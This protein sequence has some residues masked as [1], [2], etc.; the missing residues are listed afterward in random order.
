MLCVSGLPDS[1]DWIVNIITH[2]GSCL[3]KRM[4]EADR[5]LDLYDAR[6]HVARVSKDVKQPVRRTRGSPLPQPP[7]SVPIPHCRDTARIVDWDAEGE[8][9]CSLQRW[10]YVTCAS[11]SRDNCRRACWSDW[12]WQLDPPPFFPTGHI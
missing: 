7:G 10:P 3:W 9:H 2:R 12:L 11:I 6:R 8:S 4:Q 5:E 1:R